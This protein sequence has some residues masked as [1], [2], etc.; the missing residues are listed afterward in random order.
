MRQ[1]LLKRLIKS[2]LHRIPPLERKFQRIWPLIDPRVP[3]VEREFRRIWP[4]IDRIEGW[5]ISPDQERWLFE[6]ARSLP[7]QSS[8]VEIGSFKGR[9]TC[10]LAYGSRGTNTH[11][12]AIDTFNGNDFD[13]QHRNFFEEFLQNVDRC[14]LRKY[15]TPVHGWSSE[16]AKTWE[17]PIHLLF[18]DGSHRYE[19]VLADFEEFWPHVVPG[20]IVAFHDVVDTWPGPSRVWT[21]VAAPRL[22]EIGNCST[23]AFGKKPR[24]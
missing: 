20:G 7:D 13:C 3:A 8:I 2:S 10:C 6:A 4:L 18:I 12:Y 9:S 5:L 16:V 23:L 15:V 22:S 1:S 21:E 19:D 17:K 11:V 14:A 24:S